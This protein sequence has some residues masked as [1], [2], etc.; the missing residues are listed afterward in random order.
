MEDSQQTRPSHS[1]SKKRNTTSSPKQTKETNLTLIPKS[2][3]EHYKTPSSN[4]PIPVIGTAEYIKKKALKP[5]ERSKHHSA[6]GSSRSN[7]SRTFRH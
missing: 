6:G 1:K 4:S 2:S 3:S 5:P 7:H